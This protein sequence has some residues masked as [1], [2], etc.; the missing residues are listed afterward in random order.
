[1]LDHPNVVRAFDAWQDEKHVYISLE[2]CSRG[3]LTRVAGAGA[4]AHDTQLPVTF[5]PTV[6]TKGYSLT[7][8][9]SARRALPLQV[10]SGDDRVQEGALETTAPAAARPPPSTWA[11]RRPV[12]MTT[13]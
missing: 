6:T 1:M 3:D 13:P 10:R 11:R 12:V 2:H 8:A 5:S 4:R 9:R 7:P